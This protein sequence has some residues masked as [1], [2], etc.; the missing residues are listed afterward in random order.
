MK[1]FS[2]EIHEDTRQ[3]KEG[4]TGRRVMG[5]MAVRWTTDDDGLADGAD[6]PAA[7]D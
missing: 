3:G 4:Q 6:R 5:W 7:R 2:K 1:R